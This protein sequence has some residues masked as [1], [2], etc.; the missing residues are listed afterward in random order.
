MQNSLVYPW[1]SSLNREESIVKCGNTAFELTRKHTNQMNIK[2][3]HGQLTVAILSDIHSPYFFPPALDITLQILKK[4]KPHVV[5]LNGDIIDCFSIS[6]FK[7]TSKER[8]LK[9]E[10][11]VTKKLLDLLLKALPTAKFIYVEGNHEF[12]LQRYLAK[13]APSLASLEE[14]KIQNLLGI[15]GKRI[16]FLPRLEDYAT[17]GA[18]SFP[19]V[20]VLSKEDKLVLTIA[21]GDGFPVR[22]NAINKAK[23]ILSHMNGNIV[24]GHWHKYS[25]WEVYD[26]NGIPTQ[27]VT[28]PAL[29]YP[30]PHWTSKGWDL[31]FGI[32]IVSS[33]GNLF[34]E[35]VR[36]I[37][38]SDGKK[39]QCIWGGN[40]YESNVEPPH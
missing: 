38:T 15:D 7:K 21:H 32:V 36:F 29:T 40:I 37:P 9:T 28:L 1:S 3:H 14:L 26:A 25:T 17:Y 33:E 27:C 12:F 13:Q 39:L 5:I 6:V 31:G 16:I 22:G 30:K 35:V 20:K 19:A 2:V 10:I 34:I 23:N 11:C 8:D 24:C 4:V 18:D